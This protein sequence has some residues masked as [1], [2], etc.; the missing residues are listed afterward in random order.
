MTFNSAEI[1]TQDGRPVA[2]YL[3][4]WG[5]TEWCYTSADRPITYGVNNKGEPRVYEPRTVSDSGMVQGGSSQN[6]FTVTCP[7]NLPIVALFNGTPPSL[8]MWLTVR[9]M[10]YGELDAPIYWIGNVANVKRTGPA[11]AQIVGVPLTATFK[12]TGARLGWT[13][14]CPH[15]LYD[16][17]CKV[18]PEAYKLEVT[19]TAKTGTTLTVDTVDG[20]E[21][22]YYRGGMVVF[23]INGD[24][25][26]EYRMIEKN[27]G[28]VL[29]LLGLTDS[30][31]V[32]MPVTIYP[33]C[34][35]T[36]ATC[37]A[38]FNNIP[39]YGGHHY[40]PGETPFGVNLF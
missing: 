31:E 16:S 23:E 14:E 36:P 2:L 11:A 25:T 20:H 30:L 26:L 10:H 37:R 8:D 19:I 15:F 13:R 12:R 28:L 40:M 17:E 27:V 24:G 29:A 22:G 35:R 39:N 32:G 18:D 21:D 9:R 5:S 33:G 6:D 4:E 1:S 7:A 38:R 3:I 34:D